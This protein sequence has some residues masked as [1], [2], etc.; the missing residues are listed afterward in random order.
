MR[1][2]LFLDRS[3]IFRWHEWLAATLA[4]K[5]DHVVSATFASESYPLP[6]SCNLA[7][8]L[9]RLIYSRR[10]E[11]AMDAVKTSDLKHTNDNADEGPFDIVVDLDGQSDE[12]PPCNRVLTPLFNSIPGEIGAIS[13]IMHDHPLHIHINDSAAVAQGM[14]ARPAMSDRQVLLLALDG[15]LSRAVELIARLIDND[16]GHIDDGYRHHRFLR[17]HAHTSTPRS[18]I[19]HVT[20][21]LTGKVVSRLQR[22][23]TGEQTWATAYRFDNAAPLLDTYR[24]SFAVLP[25]DMRRYFA[26][27][28]P[29]EYQGQRFIF[30]EE[31]P[32]ATGR[33]CI[34]V[35]AIGRD[36]TPAR[37]RVVLDEPHHLSFPYLF[38]H[39]GQMW[40]IPESADEKRV[41]LYRAEDFPYRWT[42]EGS[43]LEGIAAYDSTLL[44]HDGHFWLL[45]SLGHWQSTSWDNLCIFHAPTL[46]GPWTAHSGNPVLID[47]MHSRAAGTPFWHNNELLRPVQ[48][49]TRIYG[50]AVTINRILSLN[51][52][53]FRQVPVGRITCNMPGC[54]TYNRR[55]GLEVID[56]F[57]ITRGRTHVSASYRPLAAS[58]TP[59]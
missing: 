45:A 33:G 10:P 27:P 50:G 47:A 8:T 51:D 11:H 38:E 43:L 34:S 56:I 9:E 18:A 13:A 20:H 6:T 59:H 48:D 41:D 49:C 40:M 5:A 58:D 21:V 23:M 1:I 12:L 36:G 22:M 35:F 53:D 57:G 44:K 42:R 7:F 3:R 30:V 25:D 17:P 31:F 19:A 54:H 37:A 39:E 52:A 29:C 32:F 16:I 24:A 4:G 28:F 14:A 15:V 55:G 2:C 46:T 26:D